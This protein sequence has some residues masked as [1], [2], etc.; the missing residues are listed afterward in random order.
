MSTSKKYINMNKGMNFCFLSGKIITD[1]DFKFF[2]NSKLHNSIVQFEIETNYEKSS[3]K[4]KRNII[5]IKAFDE[6]AD[7]IYRFYK[8]GKNI[9]MIGKVTSKYVEIDKII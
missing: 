8:K 1:V 3:K 4:L 9:K 6:N 5:Q 7:V 2:Y